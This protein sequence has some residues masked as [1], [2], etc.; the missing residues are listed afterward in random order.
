MK[1]TK[2]NVDKLIKKYGEDTVR[3]ISNTIHFMHIVLT[4]I[5]KLWV[6]KVL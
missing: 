1:V 5:T 2:A 4:D 6:E 3:D